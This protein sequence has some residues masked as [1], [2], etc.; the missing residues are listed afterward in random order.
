[1]KAFNLKHLVLGV[2]AKI[3][4]ACKQENNDYDHK[5]LC[6][7][8]V[9]FTESL[10]GDDSELSKQLKDLAEATKVSK[11]LSRGNPQNGCPQTRGIQAF[12]ARQVQRIWI[13]IQRSSDEH[14]RA[15]ILEKGPAP[16]TTSIIKRGGGKA[17]RSKKP[18]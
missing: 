16:H 18:L 17:N 2:L 13:Q 15:V 14:K 11:K 9:P 1:M 3:I 4:R 6:S 10:F 5:Q 7:S 8:S 12:Q